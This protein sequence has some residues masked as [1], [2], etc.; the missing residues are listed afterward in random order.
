MEIAV[1]ANPSKAS[2]R[3]TIEPPGTRMTPGPAGSRCSTTIAANM[4][5]NGMK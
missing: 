2:A 5:R 1:T 4:N 3:A